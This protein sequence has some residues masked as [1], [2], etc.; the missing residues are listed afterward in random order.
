MRYVKVLIIVSVLFS[1]AI[2]WPHESRAKEIY[3]SITH[4][5]LKEI[6]SV[7]GYRPEVKPYKESQ[8]VTWMAQGNRLLAIFDGEETVFSIACV[9]FTDGYQSP[10]EKVNKWN[11]EKRLSTAYWTEKDKS[12]TLEYSIN[13]ESGITEKTIKQVIL[14]FTSILE[15]YKN[16]LNIGQ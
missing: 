16:Y 15:L 4:L 13:L 7:L 8:V 14:D 12:F 1:S 3:H 9:L 10:L 2:I 11:K 6:L 5:E